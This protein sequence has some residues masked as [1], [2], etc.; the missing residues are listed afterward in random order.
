MQILESH[1][2][3]WPPVVDTIQANLENRSVCFKQVLKKS[4]LRSIVDPCPFIDETLSMN[5]VRIRQTMRDLIQQSPARH[6]LATVRFVGALANM[7]AMMLSECHQPETILRLTYQR[8]FVHRRF[9]QSMLRDMKIKFN[10]V[11]STR[12]GCSQRL[13]NRLRF[14][15]SIDSLK[16]YLPSNAFQD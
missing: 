12:D 14:N 15:V 4:S 3:A 8:M 16:A 11:Q 1:R 2:T 10:L 6:G 9:Q 7:N 5:A 13:K